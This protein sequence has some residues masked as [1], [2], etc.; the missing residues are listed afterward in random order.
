MPWY[1]RELRRSRAIACHPYRGGGVT[2]RGGY[3]LPERI[4]AARAYRS[5]DLPD[6]RQHRPLIGD[7]AYRGSSFVIS[8]NGVLVA[9]GRAIEA[10]EAPRSP[11]QIDCE[12]C[13]ASYAALT[14]E[15]WCSRSASESRA[16]A[17]DAYDCI[18]D[19]NGPR[20]CPR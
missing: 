7:F 6:I 10:L 14:R 20:S 12:R 2:P 18:S 5:Q 1:E 15:V 13:A 16:H 19:T 9:L 8:E 4:A 3:G 17:S 11:P